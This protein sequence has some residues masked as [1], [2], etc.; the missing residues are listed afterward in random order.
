MI[1]KTIND[2]TQIF[3]KEQKLNVFLER[4]IIKV[5]RKG[6]TTGEE[7]KNWRPITLLFQIY[8]LLSGVTAGRM[9]KL[10]HKMIGNSQK[11]YQSD[12]NIG[13]IVMDMIE[14][15]ALTK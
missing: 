6:G 1:G 12:R 2:A 15:I 4:G 3:I 10:L 7:I 11:A 9:K 8:K 13:K 5:L 14:T